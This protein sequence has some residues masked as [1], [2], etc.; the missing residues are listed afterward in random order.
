[1]FG[2]ASE[3]V[4]FGICGSGVLIGN[5]FFLVHEPFFKCLCNTHFSNVLM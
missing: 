4:S 5:I 3:E 2:G 1:M